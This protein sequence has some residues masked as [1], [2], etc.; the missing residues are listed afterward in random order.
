MLMQ[1]AVTGISNIKYTTYP[2]PDNALRFLLKFS[3]GAENTSYAHK[4]E[5][6]VKLA[7]ARALPFFRKQMLNE[8][9]NGKKQP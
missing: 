5:R 6:A 7:M 2:T 8:T 1:G 3:T 4:L 9:S